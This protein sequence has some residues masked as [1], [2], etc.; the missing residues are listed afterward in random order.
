MITLINLSFIEEVFLYISPGS[1]QYADSEIAA[2]EIAAKK[3][4]ANAKG[5]YFNSPPRISPPP[6]YADA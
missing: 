1:P 5:R 3:L 6:V 4:A 2:D